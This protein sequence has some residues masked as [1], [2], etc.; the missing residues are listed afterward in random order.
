VSEREVGARSEAKKGE[1]WAGNGNFCVFFEEIRDF[2]D[3]SQKK[4]GFWP[5]W[6]R[7]G[8]LPRPGSGLTQ[9]AQA[10]QEKR[11]HRA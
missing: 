10:A 6:G 3:F 2:C 5:F 11:K 9:G 8:I 1:K 4:R 7:L